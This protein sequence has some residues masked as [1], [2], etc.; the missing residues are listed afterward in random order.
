MAL[1][2]SGDLPPTEEV[3]RLLGIAPTDQTRKGE[4][5]HLGRQRQPTDV[6][7]L[8]L[9]HRSEWEDGPPLP[10]ATARAA[11]TLRSLTPGLIQLD[12]SA[13]TTELWI[14]TIR[15]EAMGGFGIPAEIVAAAGAAQLEISVSVLI[16]LE[17]DEE[18][19]TNKADDSLEGDVA[20]P[21]A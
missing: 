11:E 12:R 2:L 10:G 6:W 16:L 14:S 1:R 20:S 19:D 5:I 8:E 13:V 9:I 21:D 4:P 7:S 15:E 17:D 3:T 18:D